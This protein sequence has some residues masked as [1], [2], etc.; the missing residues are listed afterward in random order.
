MKFIEFS[1]KITSNSQIQ[2]DDDDDIHVFLLDDDDDIRTECGHPWTRD[3]TRV[4]TLDEM[5]RQCEKSTAASR[6]SDVFQFAS[7][8]AGYHVFVQ[9]NHATSIAFSDSLQKMKQQST[10]KESKSVLICADENGTCIVA[11]VHSNYAAPKTLG[12]GHRID[13]NGRFIYLLR[14]HGYTIINDPTFLSARRLESNAIPADAGECSG[15]VLPI[16][17]QP[18][19]VI[20]G[21]PLSTFQ[22]PTYPKFDDNTFLLEYVRD[23]LSQNPPKTFVIPRV[24][25]GPEH[26][27]S[28]YG[29]LIQENQIQLNERLLQ[30]FHNVLPRLKNNAGLH[31]TSLESI[32]TYAKLY[33]KAFENCDIFGGWEPHGG[34]YKGLETSQPYVQDLVDR[35]RSSDL[36]QDLV[37]RKRSSDLGQDLGDRKRSSDLGQ[38]LGDR[39]RSSD[40]GQ[41]LVDRKVI[42]QSRVKKSMF[43]ACAFDVF[44][45]IYATPW[46]HAL[47][48][49]RLLIISPFEESMRSKLDHRAELYDGVDLFPDCSFV[50]IKP[51]QTQGAEPSQEFTVELQNFE[52]AVDRLRDQYDVALVSAGGYGNLICNHLYETGKSAIYVGGVLQMYF[53]ILGTRWLRERPDV[54]RMFL[55]AHWSRPKPHER[56]KNHA[57]IESA[58]YW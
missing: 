58:C 26:N 28:M 57:G 53:G 31:I 46:T 55:N 32:L 30:F 43:W 23:C 20:D 39:K 12:L 45:Y 1:S 50:F 27:I 56:P 19:H 42:G 25:A 18:H 4:V 49:K 13:N 51:P 33:M 10:L 2:D 15:V 17:T 6:L 14:I 35:K 3:V 16:N 24:Q 47:R 9:A 37:D 34:V 54:V 5:K 29:H 11:I 7:Q 48:G 41:D 21:F 38:D 44:H 40:L 8:F 22:H 36:G 52:R